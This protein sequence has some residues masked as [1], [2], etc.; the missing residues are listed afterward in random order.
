MADQTARRHLHFASD[1][2][3]LNDAT[4][5]TDRDAILPGLA[6]PATASRDAVSMLLF[7]SS[8][9]EQIKQQLT[10]PTA[11]LTPRLRSRDDVAGVANLCFFVHRHVVAPELYWTP[12]IEAWLTKSFHKDGDV[13]AAWQDYTARYPPVLR[14][15]YDTQ[16]GT[17]NI[18][19]H[20]RVVCHTVFKNYD[21]FKIRFL[22][23]IYEYTRFED[24]VR[25]YVQTLRVDYGNHEQPQTNVDLARR[26]RSAL[27]M[28]SAGSAYTLPNQLTICMER[29]SH[30]VKANI[31]AFS[32]SVGVPINDWDQ[33]LKLAA[34]QDTLIA[35]R[36][37][38]KKNKRR[39]HDDDDD[40]KT[41]STWRATK[42]SDRSSAAK[43]RDRNDDSKP[44]AGNGK[45]SG[46][47]L[48]T[49][50]CDGCGELGH[51]IMNCPD[52][53]QDVK[54]A[55]RVKVAAN[56][57]QKLATADTQQKLS[58]MS[59]DNTDTESDA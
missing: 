24:V 2:T 19:N 12:L 54:D 46:Y 9:R 5:G 49:G 47:D 43:R 33:L 25:Q 20:G 51:S 52:T 32:Q 18:K 10:P 1:G 34:A 13:M 56:K 30:S 26:I 59:I 57:K 8:A 7:D 38:A 58:N 55:W 15:P 21:D 39:H 42:K 50:K 53:A 11:H 6:T 16:H 45:R 4:V 44:A 35:D 27:S 29:F 28:L 40:R 31:T 37:T 23:Y 48:Y 36:Y 14:D 3:V 17:E 22:G 41:K